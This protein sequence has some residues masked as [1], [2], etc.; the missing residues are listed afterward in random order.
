VTP[1]D[2]LAGARNLATELEAATEEKPVS[3]GILADEPESLG[4]S[5]QHECI[6]TVLEAGSLSWGSTMARFWGAHRCTLLPHF[7]V[8]SH[9]RKGAGDVSGASLVRALMP[10]LRAPPL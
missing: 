2:R 9:G 3:Q 4:T 10:Y 6:L 5:Q 1:S 8:S 7:F